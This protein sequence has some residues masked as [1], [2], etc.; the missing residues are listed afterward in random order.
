MN[1][2]LKAKWCR[3]LMR[4]KYF[5]L[6]TDKESVIALEGADPNSMVDVVNLEAQKAELSLFRSKMKTLVKDHEEAITN[7]SKKRSKRAT[8]SRK[9]KAQTKRTKRI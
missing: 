2:I 4:A 3:K 5:V 8:T 6:L 7:L 9:P 1:R